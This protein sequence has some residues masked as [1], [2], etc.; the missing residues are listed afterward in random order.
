MEK[1]IWKS[2][3]GYKGLYE[4][5][6]FGRVRSLDRMVINSDGVKRLWKGEIRKPYKDARENKGYLR[7]GLHKDGIIKKFAIHRLV[8][9]AFLQN[10]YNLPQVNHK[11]ENKANN[12][13]SNL[14]WCDGKY[15]KNYGTAIQRRVEK[16]SKTVLQL[17]IN[18]GRVISEYSSVA[19]A[20]R[21]LNIDHSSIS[22]CCNRKRKTAGGYKW[23]YK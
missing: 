22:M 14:E 17:D 5:S 1:E 23:K 11:D 10:P 9:K 7:V 2:V 16:Q 12:C 8:A 4:V 19:K 15:N 6:N 3:E 13:V 18:T 20:E 21:Q